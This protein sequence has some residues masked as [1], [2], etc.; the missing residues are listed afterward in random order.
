MV[1]ILMEFKGIIGTVIGVFLTLLF[2]EMKKRIGKIH[3]NVK[4]YN[5]GYKKSERDDF[6]QSKYVEVELRENPDMFHYASDIVFYN[7]SEIPLNLYDIKIIFVNNKSDKYEHI[8]DDK[9]S[10]KIISKRA[11]YEK[12]GVIDI[13]PHRLLNYE[14]KGEIYKDE[15]INFKKLGKIEKVYFVGLNYKGK[16]FEKIINC[17]N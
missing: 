10:R 2:T 12:I 14:I 16:K 1:E 5:H 13:E 7:S 8:P 9:N 11:T 3:L 6:G 17:E 15:F 4:K